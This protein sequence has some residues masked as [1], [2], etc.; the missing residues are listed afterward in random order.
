[1]TDTANRVLWI[2]VGLLLSAAGAAGIV[3]HLG[4]MPG[5]SPRDVLLGDELLVWWHSGD[6]WNRYAVIALGLLVAVLGLWLFARQFH[7]RGAATMPD[8]Q[9]RERDAQGGG[10]RVRSAGL[11]R[12][13]ERDLASSAT[14]VNADAKLTGPHSR[15]SAWIRLDLAPESD[16][17]QVRE[18]VDRSL[19]RFTTTSGMQPHRVDVTVR[20][21]ARAASRV[22]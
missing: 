12:A 16:V 9:L 17:A 18:H 6:P 5:V 14:V 8:V 21:S 7:I 10:T 1:M 4:R 20:P 22:R 19:E 3:A 15:A 11:V 2:A 13:L